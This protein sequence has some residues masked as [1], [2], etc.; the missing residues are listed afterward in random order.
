MKT[1]EEFAEEEIKRNPI[2]T[3]IGQAEVE[4]S[5]PVRVLGGFERLD[6]PA[7]IRKVERMVRQDV[8]KVARGIRV[9]VSR[10]I[11]ADSGNIG[12]ANAYYA[13]ILVGDDPKVRKV[14]KRIFGVVL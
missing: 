11:E 4:T 8:A 2:G 6:A 14:A 13:V 10:F 1:M 7:T 5:Y 12:H 9:R 3:A